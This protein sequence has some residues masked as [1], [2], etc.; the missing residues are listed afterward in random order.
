MAQ[1]EVEDE[2]LVSLYQLYHQSH[3]DLSSSARKKPLNQN[4]QRK[5][6]WDDYLRLEG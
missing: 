3:K 1:Q 4:N 5:R 6:I 2:I